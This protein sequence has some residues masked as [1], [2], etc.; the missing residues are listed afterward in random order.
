MTL[1]VLSPSSVADLDCAKKF[2]ALRVERRWPERP[3]HLGMEFGI[4]F[5]AIMRQVY[6]PRHRPLPNIDHLDAWA[7]A[8]FF[9]RRYPDLGLR[10]QEM[11]RCVRAVKNYATN[12]DDAEYTLATEVTGEFPI[13]VRGQPFFKLS[14]RIDRLLVRPGNRKCLIARDYKCGKPYHSLEEAFILLWTVKLLYPA[15]REFVLEF[16]WVDDEGHLV[17]RDTITGPSL[18]GMYALVRDKAIRVFSLLARNEHPAEP[19]E[20]CQ[21]CPLR[22]ECQPHL[23]VDLTDDRD[24]FESP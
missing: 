4:G 17:E 7:R 16:D 23:T 8:A 21:F 3:F 19:G 18:K 20:G 6:D 15:Y 9:Q 22:P 24:V 12:D 11:S 2:H 1:P 13:S 14:S 10:D 5:H